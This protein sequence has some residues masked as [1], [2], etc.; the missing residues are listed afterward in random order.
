MDASG[1]GHQSRGH[2]G[3]KRFL[4]LLML[5]LLGAV[6]KPL[7]AGASIQL[8]QAAAHSNCNT[9]A[10]EHAMAQPCWEP[11]RFLSPCRHRRSREG[12]GRASPAETLQG[13]VGGVSGNPGSWN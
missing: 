7:F 8:L 6:E 12:D 2:G 5:Q 4:L 13:G 10:L 1:R 3:D 11:A 9:K